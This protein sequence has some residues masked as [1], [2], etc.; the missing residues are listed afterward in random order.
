MGK[1]TAN[2]AIQGDIGYKDY[3]LKH[4]IKQ[5][6]FQVCLIEVEHLFFKR[7]ESKQLLSSRNAKQMTQQKRELKGIY[8][9]SGHKHLKVFLWPYLY[10]A[11]RAANVS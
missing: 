4:A 1:H 8:N 6:F 9:I 10:D 7:P 11:A 3:N 2:A 5:L